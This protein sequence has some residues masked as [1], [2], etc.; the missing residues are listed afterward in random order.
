MIK[1]GALVLCAVAGLIVTNAQAADLAVQPHPMASPAFNWRPA[2]M[3][4][5]MAEQRD[6]LQN[7]RASAPPANAN[8]SKKE[9]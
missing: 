4:A 9:W 1:L 3:S 2:G 7:G 6:N 5:S 8:S